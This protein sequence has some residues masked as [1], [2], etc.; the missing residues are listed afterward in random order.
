MGNRRDQHD[1]KQFKFIWTK[2]GRIYCRTEQEANAPRLP[3]Q[4]PP[5]PH[6]V[7]RPEDL[8]KLGFSKQ[9]IDI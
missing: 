2:E 7:N 4:K 3:N 6:T 8:S 9:E 5:R 1:H